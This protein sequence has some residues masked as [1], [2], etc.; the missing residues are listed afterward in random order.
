MENYVLQSDGQCQKSI[1]FS[2]IQ[3]NPTPAIVIEPQNLMDQIDRN[4]VP[5]VQD[6]LQCP[7][8][9]F[10][11]GLSNSCQ[12]CEEWLPGCTKCTDGY[13]CQECQPNYN[14]VH[15]LC[16]PFNW[17]TFTECPAGSFKDALTS[18][19]VQCKLKL[20]GCLRCNDLSTCL[21]CEGQHVLENG[22]CK[23]KVYPRPLATDKQKPKQKATKC[24]SGK[25]LLNG[26]CKECDISCKEC[27]SAGPQYCTA[28]DENKKL[29]KRSGKLYGNCVSN[30]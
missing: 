5:Y 15:G 25:F 30:D 8:G 1:L 14:L 7:L 9:M 27:I 20:P 28:C 10:Q 22:Q 24:E 26:K 29:V 3:P 23:L 13:I 18:T 11:D 12:K 16:I 2:P 17:N 6:F 19:C 21:E 4:I